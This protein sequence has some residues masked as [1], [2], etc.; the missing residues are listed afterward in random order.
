HLLNSMEH[1]IRT[2]PELTV[3]DVGKP[4]FGKRFCKAPFVPH[5]KMARVSDD[6]THRRP[7]SAFYHDPDGLHKAVG[8]ACVSAGEI[9]LGAGSKIRND[10]AKDASRRQHTHCIAQGCCTFSPAH[11]FKNMACVDALGGSIFDRKSSD[12][13]AKL[14][15][16]REPF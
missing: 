9:A 2:I 15:I 14:R 8:T 1:R 13:V 6:F 11:V 5:P 12:N 10:C 3:S 16:W 7:P 4:R